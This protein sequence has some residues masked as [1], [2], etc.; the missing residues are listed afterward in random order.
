MALDAASLAAYEETAS[1]MLALAAKMPGY[2]GVDGA[3]QRDGIGITISYWESEDA[4]T[5]WREEVEH[6]EA[7]ARGKSEWYESYSLKVARI[8]RAYDWQT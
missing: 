2:L 3:Y 1:R 5:A 4:I 6:S 8:E 7:R